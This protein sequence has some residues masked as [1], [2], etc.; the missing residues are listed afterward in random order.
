[1]RSAFLSVVVLSFASACLQAQVT[2]TGGFVSNGSPGAGT[3]ACSAGTEPSYSL[4]AVGFTC[5]TTI[6]T[7]F[8]FVMPASPTGTSNVPLIA[9]LKDSNGNV[10]LSFGTYQGNGTAVC[11]ATGTFTSA[12]LLE[13]DANSNV[14]DSSIAASSVV[15]GAGSLTTQYGLPYTSNVNGTVAQLGPNTSTTP[16]FLTMTGTGSAGA[17]PAWTAGSG[18]TAVVTTADSGLSSDAAATPLALDGSGNVEAAP[19]SATVGQGGIWNNGQKLG[20]LVGNLSTGTPALG[21]LYVQS[22]E[23]P[24]PGLNI[25]HAAFD[26]TTAGVG[27]SLT[28]YFCVYNAAGSS[29]LWSASTNFGT[30]TGVQVASATQYYAVPGIYQVGYLQVGSGDTAAVVATWNTNTLTVNL[31]NKEGSRVS[32]SG[33]TNTSCPSSTSLSNSSATGAQMIYTVE[34]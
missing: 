3:V 11:T 22:I 10:P 32:T 17:A 19:A 14:K 6:T 8:Y 20:Q 21:T 28:M 9:G 23:V 34:P 12:N 16:K 33:T 24:Y 15:L 5:P 4:T 13:A 25:G 7:G 26:V 27:S 30:G 29:L 2:S 31:L 18:N 1:M